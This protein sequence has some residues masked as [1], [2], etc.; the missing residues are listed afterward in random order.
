MSWLNCKQV[1]WVRGSCQDTMHWMHHDEGKALIQRHPPAWQS[2]PSWPND[3]SS[4]PP[5]Q[6]RFCPRKRV[7][8]GMCRLIV[9]PMDFHSGM[10]G[11]W[12][13]GTHQDD[14]AAAW[15]YFT[16]CRC[17][18]IARRPSFHL[19]PATC[20]SLRLVKCHRNSLRT[21]EMRVPPMLRM[22]AEIWLDCSH[23]SF[24]S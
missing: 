24:R 1:A 17:R 13:T 6:E 14:R 4:R 21:P 18:R 3:H 12:T 7:C 9:L 5:I 15:V 11:A 10:K 23:S 20:T 8:V 22:S 19:R 2:I 16:S